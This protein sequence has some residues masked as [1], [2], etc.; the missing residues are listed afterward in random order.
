MKTE[1]GAGEIKSDK[2]QSGILGQRPD[3]QGQKQAG[4]LLGIE[5]K[6]QCSKIRNRASNNL[7]ERV[8]NSG[9]RWAE[10]WGR[11]TR[12]LDCLD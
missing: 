2:K 7:A 1:P 12:V 11:V 4:V 5:S 8:L 10:D 9:A 6:N 3:W